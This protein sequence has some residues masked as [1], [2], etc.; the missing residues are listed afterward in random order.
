MS[1]S[2]DN[3][4]DYYDG[5]SELSVQYCASRAQVRQSLK[6]Q[7]ADSVTH[8]PDVPVMAIIPVRERH[9]FKASAGTCIKDDGAY[10]RFLALLQERAS[11]SFFCKVLG[12]R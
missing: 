11:L 9:L 1:L 4:G 5:N 6:S 10:K 8:S 12:L 2:S 3:R 7:M